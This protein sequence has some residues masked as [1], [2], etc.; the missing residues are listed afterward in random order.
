MLSKFSSSMSA[1]KQQHGKDG[2]DFSTDT[3]T[4]HTAS[5]FSLLPRERHNL[6]LNF[7][8]LWTTY[9]DINTCLGVNLRGTNFLIG[10]STETPPPAPILLQPTNQQTRCWNL[11]SLSRLIQ[12]PNTTQGTPSDA[13]SVELTEFFHGQ[14][15]ELGVE[16]QPLLRVRACTQ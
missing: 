2:L 9:K 3:P 5:T 15:E 14:P 10:S 16:T 1:P 8:L 13:N 12:M 7:R 4:K 6:E 11:N